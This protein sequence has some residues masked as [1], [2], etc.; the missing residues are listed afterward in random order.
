MI[1]GI[2]P[3]FSGS[4]SGRCSSE[5]LVNRVREKLNELLC[6]GQTRLDPL[7]FYSGDTR[8]WNNL[9]FHSTK[10]II[11]D[12]WKLKVSG[13]LDYPV[14]KGLRRPA[15]LQTCLTTS[16]NQRHC[17]LADT[18]VSSEDFSP[19]LRDH[20]GSTN[21]SS[22]F[23]INQDVSDEVRR[24][25]E[26]WWKQD[27]ELQR[28]TSV[29]SA[30]PPSGTRW[31]P[32]NIHRIIMSILLRDRGPNIKPETRESVGGLSPLTSLI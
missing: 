6:V 13:F 17:R 1:N 27:Q 21:T 8:L 19:H 18:V 24:M 32:D 5:T 25:S 20:I 10:S 26:E 7:I 16:T 3:S 4:L 2:D 15:D 29:E 31:D 28:S 11:H 30:G 14:N 22:L 12:F 23:A 9:F